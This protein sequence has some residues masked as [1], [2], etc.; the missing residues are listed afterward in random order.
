MKAQLTDVSVRALRPAPKQY[1]VWDTKTRGFGVLVS[2]QTKSWFVA[3]GTDRRLKTLGRYPEIS[4][5]EARKKA[6]AFLGSEKTDGHAPRF[7]EA[8]LGFYDIHLP[9]LKPRTQYQVKRVLDRHFVPKFKH[10]RLDEISH[11]EISAITDNLARRAPSEAWHTFKDARTFFR[12]CVPRYINH[13]PMEGLRSPTKY[14]PRKRVLTN[15][16]IAEVWQAAESVGYPFGTAVKLSFLWGTRWGETI[17]CRRAYIDEQERTITLPVTKNG[18]EHSYPYG[19]MTAEILESIPRYNSTDLL[20]PG[21]T[22]EP[23]NGSGKAKWEFK[24]K[25]KI[26][27]WQLLDLRRTFATKLAEL[28]VPPHIVER[29]LNHKLGTLKAAGVI[30]AVASIYN[31]HLYL[32]EMRDAIVLYETFLKGLLAHR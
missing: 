32:Q 7:S 4:L 13:S 18:T 23:W 11:A 30:T 9:T 28:K 27:P 19:D 20:F 16:E 1:K 31:R 24:E 6:L 15:A 22:L 29:L 5:A 25:C 10:K 21:K 3:F 8:L 26:A 2:G 12:W 17:G 14:V